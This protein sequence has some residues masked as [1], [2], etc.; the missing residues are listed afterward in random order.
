M[1]NIKL[2]SSSKS[3]QNP[4]YVWGYLLPP[5][6]KPPFP[7]L[8]PP[9]KAHLA[10]RKVKVKDKTK[11]VERRNTKKFKPT[12]WRFRLR[13]LVAK[14]PFFVSLSIVLSGF[15]ALLGTI[16]ARVDLVL[17]LSLVSLPQSGWGREQ[18]RLHAFI[19]SIWAQF[20][21]AIAVAVV[22][23]FP[24]FLC[25]M[26]KNGN[27]KALS[28]NV[29]RVVFLC[30]TLA[31]KLYLPQSMSPSPPGGTARRRL[32]TTPLEMC[33]CLGWKLCRHRRGSSSSSS[34]SSTTSLYCE[35][36]INRTRRTFLLFRVSPF[37]YCPVVVVVDVVAVGRH[38]N[39]KFTLLSVRVFH[40]KALLFADAPS[41]RIGEAPT[42]ISIN[43]WAPHT[44][45]HVHMYI[46][47]YV[48]VHMTIQSNFPK[49][50]LL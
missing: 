23:A 10:T 44:Y 18:G 34:S 14:H 4:S 38:D 30:S 7:T 20:F 13:S 22:V 27:D 39:V 17:S 11:Y 31:L 1:L 48:C 24:L 35:P 6:C 28:F 25:G 32:P 26:W 9:R 33:T 16:S 43:V 50:T 2:I 47:M 8:I 40:F 45:L 49:R 37:C 3:F 5:F 36:K 46:C 29:I 21:V 42:P 15:S 19:P 12:S 41:G